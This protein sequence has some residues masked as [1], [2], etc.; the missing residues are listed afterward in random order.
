MFVKTYKNITAISLVT[1]PEVIINGWIKKT[2]VL[3]KYRDSKKR[4]F[5]KYVHLA[6]M[7]QARSVT[8]LR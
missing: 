8:F 3:G 4:H 5:T 1:S 2:L 7:E 6:V